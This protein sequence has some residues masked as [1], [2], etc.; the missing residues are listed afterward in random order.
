QRR[1]GNGRAG[2][3]SGAVAGAAGNAGRP[4][5]AWR[6]PAVAGRPAATAADGH[7]H[8]RAGPAAQSH[9]RHQQRRPPDYRRPASLLRSYAAPAAAQHQ[10]PRPGRLPA[11]RHPRPAGTPFR[12]APAP[13]P[14]GAV[15]PEH[16]ACAGD[17]AVPAVAPATGPA[18]PGHRRPAMTLTPVMPPYS[19]EAEQAVLGG[20]LLDNQAWDLV[21]DLLC[22][23]DF[24]R[25]E[26]RLIFRAIETLA[27]QNIPFD[28]VTLAE[29]LESQ[30]EAGGL[31]YLG[32]LAKNIPSVANL[33]T[34]AQI[35][36]DR[37]HRRRLMQFGFAC[38]REANESEV[39]VTDLQERFEQRLFGLGQHL[40]THEFIDLRQCLGTVIDEIDRHFNAGSVTTGLSSG[41]TILDEHTAGFQPADLI[42]IAARPS[43]GKTSLALG[44]LESALLARP[45]HSVQIYSLEMPARA[46]VYR[47]LA[48]LG[49]LSLSSLLKGTLQ[50]DDWPRLSAAAGKLSQFGE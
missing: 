21:A 42:I 43:M 49:Q 47:L 9:G 15:L 2:G 7:P 20:L 14:Q 46:L 24:F 45:Q 11:G 33:H 41:L 35:V 34:Y 48:I 32:E 22:G 6:H 27:N 13:R 44:L 31:A 1:A 39:I 4:R 19:D 10:H 16:S 12:T 17:R 3:G 50:D 26:H 5:S 37:A 28:V 25:A 18:H 30:P 40:Q 23:E 29:R 38:Y 36:R 8:T